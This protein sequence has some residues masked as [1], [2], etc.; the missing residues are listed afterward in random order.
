MDFNKELKDL[1]DQLKRE[2]VNENTECN[3]VKYGKEFSWCHEPT[4][5][6]VQVIYGPSRNIAYV[7]VDN[8]NN[9]LVFHTTYFY[10]KDVL[11]QLNGCEDE[12]LAKVGLAL[13][14]KCQEFYLD[15]LRRGLL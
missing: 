10:P 13:K 3:Q 15:Y 4:Q 6:I 9:W 7:Y 12:E 8:D 11:V 2:V 14:E 5:P 1:L